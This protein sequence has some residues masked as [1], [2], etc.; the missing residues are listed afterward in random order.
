MILYKSK[1]LQFLEAWHK[2]LTH[3]SMEAASREKGI[4]SH[5]KHALMHGFTTQPM[6]RVVRLLCQRQIR[7]HEREC[8]FYKAGTENLFHITHFPKHNRAPLSLPHFWTIHQ[9]ISERSEICESAVFDRRRKQG[10]VAS[11]WNIW[12]TAGEHTA[13]AKRVS[14]CWAHK[15]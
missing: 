5:N 7:P 2:S 8:L 10:C 1:R 9:Q 6:Q 11:V 14:L 12:T 15:T 3:H 4:Y 13:R